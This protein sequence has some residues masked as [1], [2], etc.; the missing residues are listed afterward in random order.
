M[1]FTCWN[2]SNVTYNTLEKHKLN[3]TL[4]SITNEKKYE[5]QMPYLQAVIFQAKNITLTHMQNSY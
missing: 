5:N 1:S 2:A 4:D 3:S